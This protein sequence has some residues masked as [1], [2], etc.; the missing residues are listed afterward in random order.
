MQSQMNQGILMGQYA[1]TSS[2][3]SGT[4]HQVQVKQSN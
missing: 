2:A 3:Q 1:T 4:D